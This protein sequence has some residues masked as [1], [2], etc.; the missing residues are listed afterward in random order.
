ML[1]FGRTASA[2]A[3]LGSRVRLI[4]ARL[5]L[6][7]QYTVLPQWEFDTVISNSLLH[8]L[9]DPLV[10]WRTIHLLAAKHAAIFVVDLTR[11]ASRA[12]AEAL[13]ENYAGASPAIL[14]RDFLHSLCAAYR[15]EEIQRQ[16][17]QVGLPYLQAELISDRHIMVFGHFHR[18]T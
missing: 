5:P 1:A 9:A 14:K 15:L 17:M 13:V 3:G 11:P 10:L 12:E 18:E 4:Q 8:H 7:F 2:A 16:L 6:A